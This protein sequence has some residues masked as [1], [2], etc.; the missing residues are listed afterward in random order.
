MYWCMLSGPSSGNGSPIGRSNSTTKVYFVG[1]E[2]S[3][4]VQTNGN[5][6]SRHSPAPE[7]NKFDKVWILLLVL[8]CYIL[9]PN[10]IR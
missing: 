9:A 3:P 6:H 1:K 2:V 5:G 7:S 8:V 10:A 4:I